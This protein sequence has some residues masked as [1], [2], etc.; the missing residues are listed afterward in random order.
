MFQQL[1]GVLGGRAGPDGDIVPLINEA[2]RR[3]V[4]PRLYT[5]LHNRGALSSIPPDAANFL[6]DVASRNRARNRQLRAQLEAAVAALNAADVVPV[7]LKG[8]VQLIREGQTC[9]R[10]LSDIDLLI[11]PGE[12]DRSIEA[13]QAAGMAVVAR[14]D[15][16]RV[17]VVAEF[18]DPSSVGL[19]DLHQ[20]PAGP[21]GLFETRSIVGH[22]T[23]A[24]GLTGVARVPDRAHAILLLVLHDHFHDGGYWRGD[25]DLRHLL[26]LWDF[27][28]TGPALDRQ[29]VLRLCPSHLIRDAAGF[30]LS[31]GQRWLGAN[32]RAE[33]EA[34]IDRLNLA[35]ASLQRTQPGVRSVTG[36]AWAAVNGPRLLAHRKVLRN[37]ASEQ[38]LPTARLSVSDRFQRVRRIL[39]FG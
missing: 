15:G 3:L 32:V 11:E 27:T 18:G 5:Q 31:A 16:A 22:C 23:P 7:L 35:R 10:I 33:Q 2:N 37:A 34:A 14:Y 21:P 9:D 20:R 39:A 12:I 28:A 30:F 8:A 13:M 19:I 26:D 6:A 36:C 4:T 25:V 29:E 38:G 24:T 17:H 1:C